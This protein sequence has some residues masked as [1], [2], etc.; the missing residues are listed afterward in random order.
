ML[1]A[2]DVIFIGE[3]FDL[4]LYDG[5]GQ[6]FAV[7]LPVRT[8]GVTVDR[9]IYEEVL[10]LCATLDHIA[11]LM[12]CLDL[13]ASFRRVLTWSRSCAKVSREPHQRRSWK[14]WKTRW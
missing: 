10:A 5:M 9:R 8:F 7:L 11:N 4:G 2:A 12:E 1:R 14:K 3:L 6:A 13:C